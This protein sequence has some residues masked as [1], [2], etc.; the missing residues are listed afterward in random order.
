MPLKK[1]HNDWYKAST[2]ISKLQN[3]AGNYIEEWC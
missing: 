1:V 3:Q 2:A